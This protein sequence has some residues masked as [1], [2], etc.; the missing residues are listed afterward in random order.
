MKKI[1]TALLLIAVSYLVIS[2][3]YDT[4][5]VFNMSEIKS[6]DS[7]AYVNKNVTGE[8]KQV[9]FGQSEN[10]ED[11]SA[12][13][14]SSIVV[15]YRSFDTL[16]EVTVLFI[17]SL[18]VGFL[19]AGAG[20]KRTFTYL[21][22]FMLR[23]G[24]RI[25]FGFILLLGIY[26][27][28]HGHLTPGGGFPGGS[29]IATAFLLLYLGDQD[30]RAKIKRFKVLESAMGTI[31]VLLGLAGLAMGL[32]FLEN[33]IE[34]GVV[35]TLLSGGLLPIIY[36]V[37]GLKVGSELIGVLDKFMNTKDEVEVAK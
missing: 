17:A 11:G 22:N 34:T 36:V 30:Y 25:I 32:T 8:T 15:N 20:A 19:L 31:Y 21:P 9:I 7:I 29:L 23:I 35:G 33:Y 5:L 10:L 2:G 3:L 26:M 1:I 24:T 4:N 18:G 12:N 27:M 16:G 6:R 14:V 28:S 37:I 13:M